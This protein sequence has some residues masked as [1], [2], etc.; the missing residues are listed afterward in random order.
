MKNFIID[1]VEAL[2]NAHTPEEKWQTAVSRSA[3]IGLDHILVAKLNCTTKEVSWINTNMPEP[4]MEEYIHENYLLIDPLVAGLAGR[5]GTLIM[6]SGR[7]YKSDTSCSKTYAFNHGL[8]EHS[9]NTLK[10]TRFEGADGF[11]TNVT[12]CSPQDV[13][14]TFA[15]SPVDLDI[16][17]ALLA[18]AIGEP[19][20]SASNQMLKSRFISQRQRE[21]LS[22]L[23]EGHQTARI[24]EILGVTEAAINKH[25]AA[26][27]RNLGAATRE[28]ALAI[29]LQKGLLDL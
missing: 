28:Q 18:T 23:A 27:R 19:V 11:G 5:S 29:A 24:A 25:F 13:Q 7:L 10:C 4:W 15:A 12:L 20:K 22:L 14:A 9:L 16:Y 3:Q 26:A 8:K 2:A 6:E 21:V 17:S 1:T